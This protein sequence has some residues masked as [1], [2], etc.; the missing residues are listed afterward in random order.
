MPNRP[1]KEMPG[2]V[3]SNAGT[4]R[5]S[6]MKKRRKRKSGKRK[7][8]MDTQCAEDEKLEEFGMKKDGRKLFAGGSRAK[9]T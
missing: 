5:K 6:K 8:P 2:K 4:A 3:S 7:N 1:H 9:G